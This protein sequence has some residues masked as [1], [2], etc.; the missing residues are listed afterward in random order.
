MN[1]Q[2]EKTICK[3]MSYS[4]FERSCIFSSFLV[5]NDQ[6][7][8]LRLIKDHLPAVEEMALPAGG[9]RSIHL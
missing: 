6:L 5:C 7:H 1:L 3:C 9:F 8:F 4:R 2:D